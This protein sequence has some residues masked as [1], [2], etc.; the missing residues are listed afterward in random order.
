MLVEEVLEACDDTIGGAGAGGS[1]YL[2]AQT[3]PY[4]VTQYLQQVEVAPIFL[5]QV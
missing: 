3:L 5:N 1:I 4:R 2:L